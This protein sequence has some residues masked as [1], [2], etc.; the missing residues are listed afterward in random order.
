[1]TLLEYY[2]NT[3]LQR[4][5]APRRKDGMKHILKNFPDKKFI[6]WTE[7]EKA[8]MLLPKNLSKVIRPLRD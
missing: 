1:M 4:S 5:H 3:E 2:D 7:P 8:E 6:F